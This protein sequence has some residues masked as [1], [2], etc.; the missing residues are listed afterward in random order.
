MQPGK[1]RKGAILTAG[2]LWLVFAVLYLTGA[3]ERAENILY[4]NIYQNVSPVDSRIVIIGID[5]ES[6]GRIGRW[7]WPRS[8]IADV[9]DKLTDGGAAA[10]G[11]DLL[12]DMPSREPGE[13]ERLAQ[14]IERS[15]AV[16]LPVE[17]LF[18]A[19]DAG[20][21]NRANELIMPLD[22]FCGA[23]ARLAHIK[24]LTA[25]D[26]VVRRA[27]PELHYENR[28]YRSLP[29]EMYDLYS[30]G[31]ADTADIP[32][33]AY[34][35]YYISFTGRAGWYHPVS[36][37]DVYEG[38]VQPQYFKNKLVLI[39]IYAQGVARDWQFTAIDDR[40]PTYGVEIHANMLQQLIEGDY[41]KYFSKWGGF[42]IF[43][44]FSLAAAL[45]IGLKP[46]TGLIALAVTCAAY[47]GAIYLIIKLRY[48]TQMIYAPAFC[49]AA[50]FA[51]LIWHYIQ[52]H[53][54]EIRIR[55][56]FGRYMAPSVIKKILDEGEEGLK[57]GGQ[58]LN[59][60][61]L[62]VDIRGFTPM[63]EAAQPEEVV[64]ILNEYLNLAA[65]CIHRYEGTLDKFMGDAA[66]ALW[67]APYGMPGHTMAAVSAARAMRGESAALEQRLLETYGKSVRFGIGINSGEAIIGN[68]GASFRMDYT[69]IGD[70][71][72]T[73][74]RLESEAKPGQILLSRAAA[75][76]L[77]GEGL[78]LNFLGGLKVKGREEEVLVYELL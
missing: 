77:A 4:D 15:G 12:F 26:G 34:G 60:T 73:A 40:W 38:K 41:L 19:R 66:M 45:F 59:V 78:D 6:I 44:V 56:T 32:V 43:A 37:A 76:N 33:N 1:L 61:V 11:I 17:G 24:G 10:V 65:T 9:V 30:G 7:P 29:C 36:F 23:A 55:G 54:D 16:V 27:M 52:T 51:A 48:V 46:K 72:N 47:A 67:G 70:T 5:D 53:M 25:S 20:N 39:G 18:K 8:V 22:M 3:F 35:Q 31:A 42:G 2:L 58:R 74:A 62:F 49:I 64:G 71:V 14:A 50:Y 13:D 28:V 68:I 75:D 69:A 21:S 57:L 63:S